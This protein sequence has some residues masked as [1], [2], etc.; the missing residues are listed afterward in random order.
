MLEEDFEK[1]TVFGLTH[2]SL[3][4]ALNPLMFKL[5]IA[6]LA[7]GSLGLMSGVNISS[8]MIS[9]D[10]AKY[11][12]GGL[13]STGPDDFINGL[14]AA[15]GDVL[16]GPLAYALPYLGQK[17]LRPVLNDV[18]ALAI[19]LDHIEAAA[20][21]DCK[22]APPEP[23]TPAPGDKP[24]PAASTVSPSATEAAGRTG[25]GAALAAVA[26]LVSYTLSQ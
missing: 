4:C 22:I 1:L 14:H 18:L 6:G 15:L 25:A 24:G 3:V 13:I 8:L 11:S 10:Q 20:K 5:D 23:V 16:G 19:G 21:N 7:K 2:D 12:E 26:A 9:Y 17:Y